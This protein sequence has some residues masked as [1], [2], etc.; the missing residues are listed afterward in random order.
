LLLLSVALIWGSAFVAQRMAAVS[1]SVFLFNGLRFLLAALVVLPFAWLEIRR[2]TNKLHLERNSILGIGLAG[3]FLFGGASLQQAGLRYTT[4]GNAGFITGLYVVFIPIIEAVLLRRSP[5]PAIWTAALLSAAGLFLLSTGGR[6]ALQVGDALELAG[7][8]FW[9]G[10]VLWIGRMVQFTSALQLACGQYLVCGLVS[11][12]AG[13]VFE[14]AMSI[15]IASAAWAIVYTGVLSVG[16]GYT[17]QAAAQRVA[18]PADAAIILSLEAVFA[19]LAGWLFLNESLTL[20]QFSGCLVML[21]GMLL[22]QISSL[23]GRSEGKRSAS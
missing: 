8:F 1:S 6:F 22:A 20:V 11:T 13:L 17:L 2:T 7:A 16:L 18:P 15:G 19:A 14:P 9:A 5:R 10:H 23:R 12:G 3:L 4:A 21:G